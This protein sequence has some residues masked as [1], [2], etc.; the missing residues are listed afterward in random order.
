MRNVIDAISEALARGA[1]INHIR[2]PVSA[3]AQVRSDF[4]IRPKHIAGYPYCVCDDIQN[5]VIVERDDQ[6]SAQA[7]V[8]D[9]LINYWRYHSVL[10]RML[11]VSSQ[12]F[13]VV[14]DEWCNVSVMEVSNLQGIACLAVP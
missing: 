8:C 11:V 9:A 7:A 1:R 14:G 5:A 12:V 2:I 10:P 6:N 4:G 13:D 3:L